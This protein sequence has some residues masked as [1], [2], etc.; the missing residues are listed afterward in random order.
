MK[1]EV[2]EKEIRF[3]EKIIVDN[4]RIASTTKDENIIFSFCDKKNKFN[5]KYFDIR[6]NIENVYNSAVLYSGKYYH[7]PGEY[8]G[9]TLKDSRLCIVLFFNFND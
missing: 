7:S 1:K 2:D 9:K 5:D 8:F 3:Q 6:Y 4:F